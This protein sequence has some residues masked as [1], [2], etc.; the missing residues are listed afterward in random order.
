MA[1]NTNRVKHPSSARMPHPVS[2]FVAVPF[3]SAFAL[4]SKIAALSQ[5]HNGESNLLFLVY[6]HRGDAEVMCRYT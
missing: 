1:F 6:R 3:V 2:F 4:V 5:V